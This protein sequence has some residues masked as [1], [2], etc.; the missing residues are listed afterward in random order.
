MRSTSFFEPK[1][2]AMRWCGDSAGWSR[3]GPRPWLAA[4]PACSM[5]FANP[6]G[7]QV[8]AGT[9]SINKGAPN[10]PSPLLVG[11]EIYFVSH[12]GIMT[13]ADARTG[14]VHWQERIGGNYSASPIMA[15]GKIYTQSEEGIGTVLKPGKT[16]TVLAK[17]DLKERTLASY[18]V[19]DRD[20]Y[21]RTA[22]H[23]FRIQQPIPSR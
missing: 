5:A 23:L 1:I 7:G 3:I 6:T 9:A 4:P 21:I 16:F 11:E 19:D 20:L 12:G 14:T 15:D 18:A 17:N 10:T 22:K 13:C 2:T 8:V